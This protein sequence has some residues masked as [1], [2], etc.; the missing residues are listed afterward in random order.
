METVRIINK[1]KKYGCILFLLV[2]FFLYSFWANGGM[3]IYNDSD[4]YITMHIH[5]EPMYPLFLAFFR[6]IFGGPYLT[7]AGIAQNI[8]AAVSIFFLA[9]YLAE[10]LSLKLWQEIVVLFLLLMPHLMTR[11]MSV[12]HF[13]IES[14]VMTEAFCI[15]MFN[16]F[17]MFTLK[18]VFDGKKSDTVLSFLFA[19]ILCLTRTAMIC[20]VFVWMAMLFIRLLL[21]KK[22][23]MLVI[24]ILVFVM[25]FPVRS[26]CTHIYNYGVTGYFM[27]NTYGTV[28]TLANVIY[29]CDESDGE[30]FEEGSQLRAFFNQFYQDAYSQQYNYK[31]STGGFLDN[32]IYLENC[33]DEIKFFVIESDLS[34]HYYANFTSDYYVQSKMADET[35]GAMLK[36]LLPKTLG[37]WLYSYLGLC[38]VGLIRSI[39]V[40]HP[41]INWVAVAFYL[42]AIVV[43]VLLLR[44]PK[45]AE[46][47][48]MIGFA[49]LVI[50]VNVGGTA[51]TI[52]CLSRYMVYGF[53]PFYIALFLVAD[54][55]FLSGRKR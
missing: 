43:F 30:V 27:G 52:M 26:L 31:F 54:R 48:W 7:V 35:A 41:L 45:N 32:A 20:T 29:A 15:P 14:A 38:A 22:Y 28:N 51:I 34:Q 5:R 24:P 2:A 4:Q 21:V 42:L 33:H 11:F 1:K 49:L 6:V 3:G 18:M 19:F 16:F 37:R 50:A 25:A 17:M 12:L 44:Q 40:V 10:K 36:K 8:L 47:A 53:A 39:A 23:K 9:K 46:L 55:W 13:Y